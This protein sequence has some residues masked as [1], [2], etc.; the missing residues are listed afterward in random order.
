MHISAIHSVVLNE[1]GVLFIN[2]F[3]GTDT[4]DAEFIEKFTLF[5]SCPVNQR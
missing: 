5:K 2:D 4:L 1:N 3:E